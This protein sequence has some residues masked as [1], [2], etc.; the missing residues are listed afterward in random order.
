ME[1]HRVLS[2]VCGGGGRFCDHSSGTSELLGGRQSAAITRAC[3]DSAA[4]SNLYM[5]SQERAV[6]FRLALLR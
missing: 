1:F 5:L 4:E 6:K 2:G 3:P